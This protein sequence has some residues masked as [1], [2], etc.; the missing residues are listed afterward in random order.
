M[1]WR[2]WISRTIILT[3]D[4]TAKHNVALRL[5]ILVVWPCVVGKRLNVLI[6]PCAFSPSKIVSVDIAYEPAIPAA[7]V[8]SVILTISTIWISSYRNGSGLTGKLSR[9]VAAGNRHR[10]IGP[11]AR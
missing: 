2:F 8:L 1:S 4:K 3:Y 6:A 7:I 9:F 5:A 10:L 11:P